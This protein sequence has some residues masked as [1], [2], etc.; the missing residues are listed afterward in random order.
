MRSWGALILIACAVGCDGGLTTGAPNVDGGGAS[1]GGVASG[2]NRPPIVVDPGPQS[3]DE[4]TTLRL[5]LDVRDPD[6]DALRLFA[7]GLPPGAW[8]DEAART[9]VFT[10]D[11]TQGGGRDDA[12]VELVAR[13]ARGATTTVRVPITIRDTIQLPAPTITNTESGSAAKAITVS[14]AG[15]PY[16]DPKGRAT[17]ARI[18]LPNGASATAKLPVRVFLHGFGGSPHAGAP[19]GGQFRIYPHD[20]DDTYWWGMKDPTGATAPPYTARRVLH[21]LA[22][23]LETQPGADRERVY[24]AGSSMGG[25]G[26]A[27]IGLLW[28]RH[29]AFA[30]GQLA[31]LIPRNHR[32]GRVA[33]LEPL[34]GTREANLPDGTTLEDGRAVGVWDRLD[35]TRLVD[36]S[37]EARDQHLF[38]KHGK[39]DST[40]HFGA[41]V[42]PSPLTGRSAYAAFAA[43]RVGLYAVWDEGGHGDLDPVMG[44]GWWDGDWSRASD[45]KAYLRRD[46]AF[47]AFTRSRADGDPGDG[48]GNGKQPWSASS[49]Y[50]G[51]VPVVGDTGWSGEV[52]GAINRF[53]RWDTNGVVDTLERF[54]LP[55]FLVDGAGSA[56]PR[57]GYPTKGDRYDGPTPLL[58]D[59]TPRRVRAFRCRPGE[60]I[61]WT[62][63]AASGRAIADARGEVTVVDVPVTATPTTLVLERAGW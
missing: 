18:V 27:T 48:S 9:L 4:E 3:V 61:R 28:A 49:G 20:P 35:L 21:L 8:L 43:A 26:A 6:G 55:L 15:H 10:P 24:I 13:D 32:P 23:V 60:E 56:P 42:L 37:A 45:P 36:E 33:T 30:E 59:V 50:A 38:L 63:G 62:F 54:E 16:L 14:V 29:F 39:D 7:L 31:Q 22:W 40:I 53:L 19:V 44:G 11:F 12:T 41:V 1:D 57:A 25:A 5:P 51:D 47:P 2:E 52:A 17:T 46:R 58:V 34:W